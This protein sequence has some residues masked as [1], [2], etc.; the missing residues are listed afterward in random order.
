MIHPWQKFVGRELMFLA[1]D[2]P[3]AAMVAALC[4]RK[5]VSAHP[6]IDVAL[7]ALPSEASVGTWVGDPTTPAAERF[8][9]AIAMALASA[10]FPTYSTMMQKFFQRLSTK[11]DPYWSLKVGY[12]LK[13]A[14]W[15][16]A[17]SAYLRLPATE[18]ASAK[19][20]ATAIR[21][22][23]RVDLG[24]WVVGVGGW[25]ESYGTRPMPLPEGQ[26]E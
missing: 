20:L 26:E 9:R 23:P 2:T 22:T 7:L 6:E 17:R 8:Y 3:K 19:V 11:S 4:V 14:L 10:E 13:G 5:I 24:G 18:I 21:A 1:G 25:S 12:R 16:F 15:E